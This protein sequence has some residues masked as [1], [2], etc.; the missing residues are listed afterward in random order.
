MMSKLMRYLLSGISFYSVQNKH[1]ST[2]CKAVYKAGP[3]FKPPTDGSIFDSIMDVAEERKHAHF[4][5]NNIM[6]VINKLGSEKV[7]QII[8]DSAAAN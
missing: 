7:V 8:T 1:F 3:S 5:K 4:I 6:T 2:M